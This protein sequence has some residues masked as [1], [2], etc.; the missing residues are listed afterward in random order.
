MQSAIEALQMQNSFFFP[1]FLLLST[2]KIQFTIAD[3]L[4]HNCVNNLPAWV[5]TQIKLKYWCI[6]SLL[7]CK[8]RQKLQPLFVFEFLTLLFYGGNMVT[9]FSALLTYLSLRDMM[10]HGTFIY[11]YQGSKINTFGS[12]STV[13]RKILKKI[14]SV[15]CHVLVAAVIGNS[16]YYINQNVVLWNFTEKTLFEI[17]TYIIL[18]IIS[19]MVKHN[20][21]VLRLNLVTEY[22]KLLI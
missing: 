16:S 8:I 1:S 4:T 9:H 14:I 3:C 6:Y 11:K 22:E 15:I 13:Y 5:W 2:L 21:L 20:T 19:M 12:K 10:L 17:V 18:I 7:D